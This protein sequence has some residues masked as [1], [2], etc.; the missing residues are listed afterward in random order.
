MI[1]KHFTVI[2][3]S[4]LLL[5]LVILVMLLPSFTNNEL[6]HGTQSGKT[7][8]FLWIVIGIS[9]LWLFKLIIKFPKQLYFSRIDLLLFLWTIYVLL[10]SFVR[11]LPASNRWVE[12][13]GLIVC[14]IT[15]RQTQLKWY[16]LIM[17]TIVT[18]GIMQ[19]IYGNLQLWGMY[20]SYHGIFKLTG[21]FFNPGPYA[22]YLAS[23]FP[24]AL[25]L[26]LFKFDR[27]C[28]ID[29]WK[30]K[31]SIKF[32]KI[33]FN[34]YS[35]IKFIAGIGL[36]S[37]LSVI[38]PSQSRAAWIAITVSSIL[39]LS[40][41]F[42]VFHWLKRQIRTPFRRIITTLLVSIVL[43]AGLFGLFH[44]K[45]DSANG[46]LLIWKVGFN[47][48]F[49]KQPLTG[50]GF[51]QFK[52]YYMDGQSAYFE[53]NPKS[54]EAMVAGDSQYMFN[55]FF[56][57]IIENGL[58][59][60]LFMLTILVVLLRVQPTKN[61]LLRTA[62]A[63]IISVAIFAAFSYPAQILPIKITLLFCIA[64]IAGLAPQKRIRLPQN[65]A[66][67]IKSILIAG[68]I[69]GILTGVL[70]NQH[71]YRSWKIWGQ[72]FYLYEKGKYIACLNKYESAFPM[73]QRNGDFLMNYGKALS[74]TQKHDQA[75]TILQQ[76]AKYYPNIVVY[77]ALGDSYKALGKPV[78]AEQAYL[79]AWYMNPSR[80][81]PQYLL[82][83]LYD[84]TG[85][86]SKAV[87]TAQDLLRKEI[88]I[89]SIATEEIKME[90]KKIIKNCATIKH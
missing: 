45:T 1:K 44:L 83:I 88:K 48:I 69:F 49:I 84:E 57:Q 63:G 90:M 17:L 20:S 9:A 6:M 87:R 29:K 82:A 74:I 71:Y 39:I 41:Y 22:G 51:D 60:L 26:Y 7:W 24:I 5:M 40:T 23:V 27:F 79:H 35:T 19:A 70:Y 52:T 86:C 47:Q 2:V 34:S 21:S 77:C 31:I 42:P 65:G 18:G 37:I 33:N 16:P 3:S 13:C 66:V 68:I 80:F 38:L 12:L 73:L 55:D 25:G 67:A 28:H 81:Y 8:L 30:E 53:A 10:N 54:S 32:L 72:A 46:R 43:C 50:I 64:T 11:S 59:G 14:Y 85:Q 89:E 75:V 56:Q 58:I 62:Q 78:E 61:P 4:I 15:L 36:I 76:A